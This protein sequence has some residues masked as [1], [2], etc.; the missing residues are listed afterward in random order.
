MKGVVCPVSVTFLFTRQAFYQMGG[1]PT[2]HGFDTQGMGFRFLGNGLT[3]YICP[4]TI[5][6]HR[7]SYNQSYYLREASAGNFNKNYFM[8]LD[9]W[10]FLFQDDIKEK[11]LESDLFPIYGSP[12]PQN[13]DNIIMKNIKDILVEN[14][15]DLVAMKPEGVAKLYENSKNKF[16]QYWLGNYMANQQNPTQAISHYLKAIE[17]GFD[18]RIVYIKIL[19]E[20]NKLNGTQVLIN[21][22]LHTLLNY[23]EGKKPPAELSVKEALE[24]IVARFI[25]ACR[26]PIK[27]TVYILRGFK[28]YLLS[29]KMIK[30]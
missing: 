29:K 18:Y 15:Q 14:Y 24:F 26:N 20:L 30:Q 1:Y 6:Y 22:E 25:K 28:Q 5:Y 21:D 27:A 3:A 9:E 7:V 2:Q 23:I 12:A 4:E 8:I 16:D 10:L 13:I 11:I 17:L 19:E